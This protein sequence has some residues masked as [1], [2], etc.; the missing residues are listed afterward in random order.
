MVDWHLADKSEKNQR[1]PT[2]NVT[3]RSSHKTGINGINLKLRQA[4]LF[5]G[6]KTSRH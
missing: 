3:F 4:T 6:V 2:C 1:F 5:C